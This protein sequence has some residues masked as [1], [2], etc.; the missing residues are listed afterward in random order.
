[1]LESR[2]TSIII[3]VSNNINYN[4]ICIKSI[5]QYTEALGYEIV[6]VD[7]NSTDGSRQWLEQ[8][9]D[10][11]L[12]HNKKE[13]EIPK[14]YNM[15]I[16]AADKDSDIVLL[17]NNVK[18]TPRWLENLKLCLYSNEEIGVAGAISNCYVEQ[19][20]EASEYENIEEIL[21]FAE[22]NNVSAPEK[23][24]EKI[25]LSSF[26][27]LIKREVINKTG[28]FDEGFTSIDIQS[29]DF[30]MRVVSKGY[31]VMLCKDSFVYCYQST[32]LKKSQIKLSDTLESDKR[33]FR[34]KWDFDYE[35]CNLSTPELIELVN[36]SADKKMN[37]LEFNCKLGNNLLTIKN[38]YPN[39]KI[40]GLETD[41]KMTGVSGKIFP[42]ATEDFEKEY[43]LGLE[44]P[45]EDFFDY[46]ILGNYL[47]N[48]KDIWR[49][50][51][52]I[53]R[54]LK[55]GGY[56]V[57]VMHN[58]MY[59]SII[60]SL[61]K[62]NF[63]YS[64]KSISNRNRNKLFTLKDIYSMVDECG[65]INPS[66]IYH[67]VQVPEEDNKFI[68]NISNIFEK[69][70]YKQFVTDKYI[71]KLQKDVNESSIGDDDILV[72]VKYALRRIENNI[73]IYKNLG[74]IKDFYERE[75][76]TEDEL[77][78]VI[79]SAVVNKSEISETILSYLE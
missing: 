41:R 72:E 76:L 40:Y 77:K 44:L 30:C 3:V 20:G 58:A 12:I 61:L 67:T 73:D 37:I 48:C 45:K 15:G 46:I 26:C 27:M 65:F 11:K 68:K 49:T 29:V 13:V 64:D 9:S 6:V 28:N 43:S 19:N 71:V 31:R 47:D 33:R 34:E 63:V 14:A 39:V 55:P 75:K 62:G 59:Y 53:R 32:L 79:A 66:I 8:Q 78:K 7:N 56:M 36:E 1:M 16:E 69:K 18:V 42:I 2:K 4:I 60:E 38:I 22:K 21:S 74:M 10:I 52:T 54:L 5:R 50:L 24:Q 70:L 57:A 17:S 35:L 25:T 51:R 23:W